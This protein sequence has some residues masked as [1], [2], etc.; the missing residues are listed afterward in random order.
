MKAK[1][2]TQPA[3]HCETRVLDPGSLVAVLDSY[4]EQTQEP[5][6]GCWVGL[7]VGEA[8][9]RRLDDRVDFSPARTGRAN[10]RRNAE[11]RFSSCSCR[12]S[13]PSQACRA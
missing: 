12:V 4:G 6:A 1:P 2:L 9:R 8:E 13:R 11:R 3:V 5:M 7:V 10:W